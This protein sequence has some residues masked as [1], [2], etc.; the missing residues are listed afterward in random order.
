MKALSYVKYFNSF[1]S[2][3]IAAIHF[4]NNL[5]RD[6]KLNE[7]GTDQLR[8]VYPKFMNGKATIKNVRVEP[9]FGKEKLIFTWN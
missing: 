4:N 8:F 2:H 9:K 7:D 1:H 6:N 3:I 5:Y